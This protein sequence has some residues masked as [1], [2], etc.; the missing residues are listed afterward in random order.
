MSV[1]S[2]MSVGWGRNAR[3]SHCIAVPGK[4]LQQQPAK[5]TVGEPEKDKIVLSLGR[6][7]IPFLQAYGQP[8]GALDSCSRFLN[9]SITQ[10]KA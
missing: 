10:G 1:M 8:C 2:V 9:S 4:I 5:A 3:V 6:V 7:N